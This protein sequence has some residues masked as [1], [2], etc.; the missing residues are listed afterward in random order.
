MFNPERHGIQPAP[1]RSRTTTWKE[2]LTQHWHLIVAGDFFTIE[3]W[4]ATG[5]RRFV[6]LFFR[7]VDPPSADRPHLG[8]G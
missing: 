7:A 6:V 5:L 1:E 8:C 4:T 3:A 2:F